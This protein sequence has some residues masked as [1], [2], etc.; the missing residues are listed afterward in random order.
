MGWD[1][2][3][4]SDGWPDGTSAVPQHGAHPFSGKDVCQRCRGDGTIRYTESANS[5]FGIVTRVE[6]E[7]CPD[8]GGRG[9]YGYW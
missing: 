2:S 7:E 4:S 9:R 8:C 5:F 6:N 1:Q 3:N